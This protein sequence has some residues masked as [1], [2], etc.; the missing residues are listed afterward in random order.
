MIHFS[1]S[2]KYNIFQFMHTWMGYM[3]EY[4]QY[5]CRNK[6]TYW[7]IEENLF[8]RLTKSGINDNIHTFWKCVWKLVTPSQTLT[9]GHFCWLAAVFQNAQS[10]IEQENSWL[11]VSNCKNNC[12]KLIISQLKCPKLINWL[13]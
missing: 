8:K 7:L 13:S 1:K 2:W 5:P 3:I 9:L 11:K 6:A 12:R 10:F 4:K